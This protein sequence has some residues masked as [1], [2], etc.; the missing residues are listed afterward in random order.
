MK[1][2][3]DAMGGDHAPKEIV[4]GAMKAAAEYKDIEITL[5][6]NETKIKEYLTNPDRIEILHTDEVILATDEPVR[7]VRRKKNASMVLAAQLVTDG[8]ADACIS[9]GNTGALMA[10][11]L[12]VVGRIDGI[13]RPALSPT[14]P[15]IGG[16]GFLLLDVGANVDAKPEHLL[17]YAIMGSIYSEKVRGISNPRIG[18]LNI[19]TEEKKGNE[20]TKHTFELLQN[21]NLN[22]IGNVE[23]RDLLEG[24]ADVVVTD[25]FTGNMVLKTIEGTALSVFK[26]LKSALTSSFKSKLAAAVLKPD[27]VQLKSKMDYSEYGGA[28]LFGLKAPVIKA[29][30]SSDANAVYNAVRQ[31]RDMVAHNVSETIKEVVEKHNSK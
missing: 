10:A 7:A 19:G 5:V 12:F 9:A 11:G 13:E 29:H 16:E 15:T 18:L 26:M 20:L 8:K 31:S 6:G 1:I 2:A 17:Q 22:F 4:L 30:G 23:A 21:A 28:G 27:L 24:A 3:I 25:G 14:L